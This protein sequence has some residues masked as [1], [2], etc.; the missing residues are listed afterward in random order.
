MLF[1]VPFFR[2]LDGCGT[3]TLDGDNLAD[4][5]N[6]PLVIVVQPLVIVVQA[7]SL[8]HGICHPPEGRLEGSTTM[9]RV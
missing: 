6:L 4:W 2:S 9:G 3:V 5:R 7:S 1:T 8:L